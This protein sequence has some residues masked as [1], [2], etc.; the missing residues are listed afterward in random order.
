MVL[1]GTWPQPGHADQITRMTYTPLAGG[2]VEQKLET[3]DD[4][5]KTWAP[6]DD[7]IYRPAAA[8]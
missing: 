4:G 2:S 1:T 5:G 3:S 8:G 7:L 6:S